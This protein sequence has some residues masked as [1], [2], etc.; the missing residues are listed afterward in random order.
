[1]NDVNVSYEA[2][3]VPAPLVEPVLDAEGN[4]IPPVHAEGEETQYV[5]TDEIFN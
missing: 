5:Q 1:M 3:A 4:P 2:P